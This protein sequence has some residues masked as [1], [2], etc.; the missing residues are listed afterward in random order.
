MNHKIILAYDGTSFWGWQEALG[1]PSIEGTLR[2][3]LE[4]IY[5][6]PIVLQAASRTDRGVHAEGQ[7]VNY[8]TQQSKDLN[9]LKISLNQ[10]LPEAIRVLA[11]TEEESTF[12]PTLDVR[13]KE[14]HYLV[15]TA[16][17]QSPFERYFAWHYYLPLD[18]DK[19]TQAAEY[20]KG[21][22]DFTAFCNRIEPLP[23]NPVRTVERL[24][25]FQEGDRLRFEIVGNHFLYKM[26]RNIVGTLV[27]VGAGKL[28]L[29]AARD[30][31]ATKDRT[32]GGITA[33]AHGLVLKRVLYNSSG[34]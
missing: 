33:P 2:Q 18:L 11:L 15:S 21:T 17:V 19:M 32:Q 8:H 22:H 26:V 4:Q 24:E 9:R 27:Y 29:Q 5:Q 23:K 12:H 6:E 3:V 13:G 1:G 25:I 20:F 30:L 28:S 14:Y 7:V 10:M 31:V 16:K 34:G